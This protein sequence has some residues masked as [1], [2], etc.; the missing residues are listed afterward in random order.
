MH[1]V[2]TLLSLSAPTDQPA[3]LLDRNLVTDVIRATASPADRLE[4]VYARSAEGRLDIAL[5][6]LATDPQHASSTAAGIITRA[7]TRSPTLAGWTTPPRTP[8]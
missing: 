3:R 2:M 4:H 8:P 5:F 7:L 6:L 1:L